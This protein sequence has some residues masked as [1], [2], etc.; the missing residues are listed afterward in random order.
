MADSTPPSSPKP[1]DTGENTSSLL[2]ELLENQIHKKE[3][4]SWS[5]EGWAPSENEKKDQ[6]SE[7]TPIQKKREPISFWAFMRFAGAILFVSVIFFGS[8]LAYVV[9]NPEQAVFFINIFG[10]NPDDIASLLEKLINGSFW[11]TIF[12]LSIFWIVA[13][14]RAIWTPKDLKRKRLLSWMIAVILGMLLFSILF[15]WGFLFTKISATDFTN[16]EGT[17]LIYNNELYRDKEVRNYSEIDSG[18][19]MIGPVTL[20]FD[21]R[22]NAAQIMK[23]NGV[24]IKDYKIDTDG[25]ICSDGSSMVIGSNVENE[26]SIICRFEKIKKYNISGSYTVVSRTGEEQKLTMNIPSVEIRW[27]VSITESKN[28]QWKPIMILNAE[29]LRNLGNPRWMYLESRKIVENAILS[30]TLSD[31][32][33]YVCLMV[34]TD[35]CDQIFILE[36][37]AKQNNN[38]LLIGEQDIIDPLLFHLSLSGST[39]DPGMITDIDWLEMSTQWG[40]TVICT[41]SEL[42]CDYRFSGYGIRKVLAVIKNANGQEY[43]AETELR[44]REP[45]KLS[46]NM[47]VTSID[48]VLLNTEDTYK[49]DI[50]AF[51][52]ENS[53]NPPTSITLDARDI[54]TSNDGYTLEWVIWKISNGKKIEEKRWERVVVDITDP[55]RYTIESVYTFKRS[56]TNELENA[57]EMVII[58]IERRNLIPRIKISR[59][60]DYVPAIITVDASQSES[61]NSEIKKF[62]F[63]FDEGKIPAEGDAIQE[64]EYITAGEKKIKVTIIA[65]NG[66]T[67]TITET[68]VLKDEVRTIDFVPSLSPWIVGSSIDFEALW[69]NGQVEEY[70]WNFWDNTPIVRGYTTT[71][72]FSNPWT[73]SVQLT[74]VYTDGT[75]R[76]ETRKY[77]VEPKE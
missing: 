3:G 14:F 39:L 26:L 67:A 54:G 23:K 10:I 61:I 47:K 68:V 36:K 58:D 56:N 40:Q 38:A 34:L 15:F 53:L 19:N 7:S 22:S 1:E 5:H 75:R 41:G 60:S 8:F 52:I 46:R 48:G 27:V 76:S 28:I 16:P 62:I 30:E 12:I 29:W 20:L 13:L 32:P 49:T 43:T 18:T 11:V 25:G 44:V 21:I 66:E 64:Y 71:H 69:T 59:T 17:I 35:S 37:R 31:T 70:L 63:D 4:L 74:V 42:K 33:Q 51:V 6:I 24:T 57:R 65:E 72:T 73:Y 2:K 9:F 50:K 55:L 77:T 45:L